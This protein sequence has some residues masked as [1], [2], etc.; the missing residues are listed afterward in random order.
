MFFIDGMVETWQEFW[1]KNKYYNTDL[2][3]GV[4]K[5]NSTSASRQ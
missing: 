5:L 1:F 2:K 4:N 3:Q